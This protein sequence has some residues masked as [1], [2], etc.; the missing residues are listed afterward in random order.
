[1]TC[2]KNFLVYFVF[3][4]S[5]SATFAEADDNP[6]IAILAGNTVY[7]HNIKDGTQLSTQALPN[8]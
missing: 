5:V 6:V 3:L 2:M 7:V 4:V 1:M 8:R